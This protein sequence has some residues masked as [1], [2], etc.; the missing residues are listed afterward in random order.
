[1]NGRQF[2]RHLRLKKYLT[3]N[4]RKDTENGMKL[5]FAPPAHLQSDFAENCKE[6]IANFM[7][8]SQFFAGDLDFARLESKR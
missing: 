3:E 6:K 4:T 5:D 7:I 2:L 1:V 8:R